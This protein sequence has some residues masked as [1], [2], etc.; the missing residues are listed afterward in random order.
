MARRL[1]YGY[2]GGNLYGHSNR[3]GKWL[4]GDGRFDRYIKQCPAKRHSHSNLFSIDLHDTDDDLDGQF[5]HVKC[6]F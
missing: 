2:G 5:D 6:H 3:S 4:H 1:D